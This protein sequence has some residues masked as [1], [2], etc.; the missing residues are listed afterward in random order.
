[1]SNYKYLID[2][3][4]GGIGKDGNYTTAPAKMYKHPEFTIYEG[5]IN[6][7]IAKLV[8]LGLEARKIDFGLVYD[9]VK[10]T[11]LETRVAIAD[12]AFA[13]DKRCIYISIHSNAG[14]GVGNEI[15]TSKGQTKSDKIANIFCTVYQERFKDRP[16]RA[17]QV[18]GD[19]DKEADFYVLRKTD[20]P[21]VLLE[22]GFFDNLKEA[23]F[24]RS[25]AGQQAYADAILES[26]EM[27][28]KL[29]PI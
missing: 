17:D 20:C 29:K 18:D 21:A 7:K 6:R 24:L 27:C 26:I 16:F 2:A 3:G 13:K 9:D 4:H 11:P 22:N 8:Y 14:G 19:A 10:D 1:M 15:F 5:E 23:E 12:K 28:E 25:E